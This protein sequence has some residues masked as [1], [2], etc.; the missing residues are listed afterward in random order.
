MNIS[1]LLKL[2]ALLLF[3]SLSTGCTEEEN[4]DYTFAQSETA[5][6]ASFEL[7][8]G[9]NGDWYFDLNAGNYE[10]LLYSE[11]Y[12]S[13]TSALNGMLSVLKNG[14][15][16][17]RFKITEGRDGQF[18]LALKA[19]NGRTIATSEGYVSASNAKRAIGACGRAV[20]GYL[21]YWNEH[22]GA[23]VQLLESGRD[24]FRFNV[25]AGNGEV[26]LSSEQYTTKAS[27]LNGAFSVVENGVEENSYKVL[28]SATG[29]FYFNLHAANHQIIAT[30][31]MY[32]TRQSAERARDAVIQLLPTIELI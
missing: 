8:Q 5:M 12:S 13:R 15:I 14:N 9:G 16:E 29:G 6:R 7:W 28:E 11:G 20:D 32:T 26:V 3:T 18:Y 2:C 23:R 19:G 22:T 4:L 25:Y 24:Q 30:S 27:A 31:E 10:S 21:A 17:S 1:T